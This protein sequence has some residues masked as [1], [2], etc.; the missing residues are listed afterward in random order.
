VYVIIKEKYTTINS[1]IQKFKNGGMIP[2]KEV[3]CILLTQLRDRIRLRSRLRTRIRLR[4]RLQFRL[5]LRLLCYIILILLPKLL[6][7]ST[8]EH[9]PFRVNVHPTAFY[10]NHI[11]TEIS[12]SIVSHLIH[13]SDFPRWKRK[14]DSTLGILNVIHVHI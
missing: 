4:L 2:S 13:T 7:P 10:H 5:Q 11:S 12:F 1:K 8:S 9:A 3:S 6:S 14:F